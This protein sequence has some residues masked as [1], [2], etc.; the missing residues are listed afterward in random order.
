M[1]VV[2]LALVL[3]VRRAIQKAPPPAVQTRETLKEDARWAR[4]QIER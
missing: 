1:I 2:A 3:I 4:Q